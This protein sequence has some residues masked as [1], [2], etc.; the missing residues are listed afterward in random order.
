VD[1]HLFTYFGY[2]NGNKNRNEKSKK[3]NI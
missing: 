1:F 2:D 3:I